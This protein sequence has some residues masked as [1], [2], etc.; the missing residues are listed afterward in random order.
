DLGRDEEAG[1]L[2][3]DA[4]VAIRQRTRRGEKDI[5]SWSRESLAMLFRWSFLHGRVGGWEKHHADR[6]RFDERQD[7][8]AARGS[9]L[10]ADFFGL[11]DVLQAEPPALKGAVDRR[12]QFDLGTYTTK[13]Q[14][15]MQDPRVERLPAYRLLRFQEE[16]GLPARVSHVDV[17]GKA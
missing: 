13:F 1:E 9:S 2:A 12:P 10:R 4:L 11:R 15:A 8:L 16:S 6:E 3:L 5:A 17:L 7:L 14:L